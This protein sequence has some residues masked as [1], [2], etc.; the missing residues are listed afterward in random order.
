MLFNF[1]YSL[2]RAGREFSR[3]VLVVKTLRKSLYCFLMAKKALKSL[4]FSYSQS[5]VRGKR[6]KSGLVTEMLTVG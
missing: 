4:E 5:G 2:S 6:I 1:V 3:L